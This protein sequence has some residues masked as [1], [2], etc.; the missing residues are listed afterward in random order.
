[1]RRFKEDGTKRILGLGQGATKNATVCVPPLGD[2][3][4]RGLNTNQPT[5]LVLGGSKALHA[6]VTRV[7]AA[8]P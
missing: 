3:Q 5:L 4:A 6:A 7:W 1:M 2:L 8:T